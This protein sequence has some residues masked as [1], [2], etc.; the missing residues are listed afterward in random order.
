M[1]GQ[2]T[3]GQIKFH[4]ENVSQPKLKMMLVLLGLAVL[5]ICHNKHIFGK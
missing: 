1:K 3:A 4:E 5:C 2:S